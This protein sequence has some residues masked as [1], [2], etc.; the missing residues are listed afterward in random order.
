MAD[1]GS[2]SGEFIHQLDEKCRLKLPAKL[3]NNLRDN[4]GRDCRLVRM[5]E[6]CIAIYPSRTWHNER[7]ELL[8]KLGPKVPGSAD[9]RALTRLAG[10]T[11]LEISIGAQGR[12]ALTEGFRRHIEV[13]EGDK[14]AVVGAEDRIEIWKA[15]NWES[16][17][18]E[19]LARYEE[20]VERTLG[21]IN[22]NGN[23]GEGD[24]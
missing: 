2:F 17:L 7:A 10:A 16:Y 4:F 8:S 21:H 23:R 14:V 22:G 6:R 18:D 9:A 5:P 19:Q 11:S 15:E 12:V 24:S 13:N 20:I 3:L 1:G